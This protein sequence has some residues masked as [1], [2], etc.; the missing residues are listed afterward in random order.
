VTCTFTNTKL[1][2]GIE[3]VKSPETQAVYLDG[4]ATYTYKVTNTGSSDLTN[5]TAADDKCAPLTRTDAG[6]NDAENLLEQG[7]TWTYTCSVAASALFGTGTAPITN[8]VTASGLDRTETKVQDTDTAV[9]TLLVPGIAIDKTG[10]ATATAGELITYDLAVT[11]TGN[12]SFAEGNVK[13]TDTV[14][15]GGAC[16]TAPT[17]PKDK[18]GDTSPGEL[19]PG[20]TW[21]YQCQVQTKAGDTKVT[22]KGDVSG[23]DSGGRTVTASDTAETVLSAPASNV[24]P[25]GAVSGRARLTG[26]VGC[27]SAKYSRATVRGS[28]IKQVTFY[29]NGKKAKTLTKPNSGTTG[30]QIR[31]L[32]KTLRYGTYKVRAKVQFVTGASPRSRDLNLQF[33]RCRPRVIKPKFT[34]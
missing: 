32:T 9:T 21:V 1:T 28:N 10:P 15:T 26:T 30:Y 7:E 27:A 17:T 23:T 18:R 8:T 13:L 24:S 19:N 14:V 29:V 6:N 20:E 34:G 2:S 31:Y 33:N 25:A 12:T 11:N 16:A 22:N 5:V 4:T 3:V